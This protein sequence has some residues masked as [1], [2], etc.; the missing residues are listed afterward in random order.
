V[1][2][3]TWSWCL[4]LFM[5]IWWCEVWSKKNKSYYRNNISS[6]K[7]FQ[8]MIGKIIGT[9]LAGI[10]QFYMGF[11]WLSLC[12]PLVFFWANVGNSKSFS[13]IMEQAQQE[14]QVPPKCISRMEFTNSEYTNKFY[15]L[16]HRW[17]LSL[18]LFL[19]CNGA[20]VDNQTDSQQFLY[21][22]LCL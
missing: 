4:L 21:P 6:V 8:L 9:S 10:L 11:N 20:A 12:L 5:V 19:C 22:L 7:P 1:D 15:S 3:G 14:F 18:Q 13:R 2:L 17:L 16:F